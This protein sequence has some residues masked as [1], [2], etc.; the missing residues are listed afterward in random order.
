MERPS[1]YERVTEWFERHRF[2]VDLIVAAAAAFVTIPGGYAS[3]R[4]VAYG[5]P[6][7]PGLLMAAW[8]GVMTVPFVWVRTRPV[9]PAFCL[10]LLAV[11]HLAIGAPLL[12]P[13]DLLL[14]YA[15]YGL[16][17]HGPR[18]APRATIVLATVGCLAF[19]GSLLAHYAGDPFA[20]MVAVFAYFVFLTSWALGLF[21]RAR[22]TMLD[23]LRDRAGRLQLER[24]QQAEI[25]SAAERARIAR[26]MHDIVAHS[27]SIVIAQADGGRY[28]AA[29]DPAAAERSLKTIAETGRAALADMRKILGV[30]RTGPSEGVPGGAAGPGVVSPSGRHLVPA[31]GPHG[32]A[33][34]A[35]GS[36]SPDAGSEVRPL[37]PQPDVTQI[38]ALVEQTRSEGM[39]VSYA[40]VGDERR[41]PPGIGLNI[42]RVAQESLTNVRKHAGPGPHVTVLVRWGEREVELVVSDDGR[43]LASSGEPT[44]PGSGYGLLGMRERAELLGGSL[45]AGPKPGGGFKVRLVVPLPRTAPADPADPTDEES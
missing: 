15:A 22:R 43:G 20:V 21:R 23:A 3:A 42:Y 11:G 45:A 33:P 13:V 28:A 26:E 31:A 34:E 10:F 38:E 29:H 35:T 14:P 12:L 8:A 37:A 36:G 5:M 19:G 2:A 27:L 9:V 7:M 16:T 32:A 41:L 24:D 17:A 30:L 40:R 25:A 39:R 4:M 18:W 1:L 44:A 6:E